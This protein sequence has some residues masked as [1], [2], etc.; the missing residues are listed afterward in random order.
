MYQRVAKTDHIFEI[1]REVA[2]DKGPANVLGVAQYAGLTV[3]YSPGLGTSFAQKIVCC[4][5]FCCQWVE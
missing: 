5:L 2:G 1:G 4:T 3:L